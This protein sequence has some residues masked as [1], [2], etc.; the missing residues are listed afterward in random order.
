V[1][2]TA[3]SA[4]L[5]CIFQRLEGEATSEGLWLTSTVVNAVNDRFR[6]VA[7]SVARETGQRSADL[8]SALF[9]RLPKAGWKPVVFGMAVAGGVVTWLSQWRHPF[10]TGPA[11]DAL[12]HWRH[13]TRR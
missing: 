3:G 10:V 5:R 1:I 4:Q 7:S 8:Q 6:V 9:E 11:G 13:G 2:P 12:L